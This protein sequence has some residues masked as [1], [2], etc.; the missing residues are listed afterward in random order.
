MQIAEHA[1]DRF[2]E[3]VDPRLTRDQAR[4]AIAASERVID[5]A[6]DFGAP[7]VRQGSGAILAL[8]GDAVVTVIARGKL[9]GRRTA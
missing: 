3:R 5:I 7:V 9:A 8:R 6:A 4:D 1:I 2:M